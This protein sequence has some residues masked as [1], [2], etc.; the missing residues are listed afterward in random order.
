MRAKLESFDEKMQKL[1]VG[2]LVALTGMFGILE[3]QSLYSGACAG[4]GSSGNKRRLL[5]GP[6]DVESKT[7]AWV[8]GV[9]LIMK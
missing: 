1:D 4:G 8:T 5:Q 7:D 6:A 2:V 3:A 9:L